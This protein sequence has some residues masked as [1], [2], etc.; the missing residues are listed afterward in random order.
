[1]SLNRW[2][3]F[4][5]LEQDFVRTLEFVEFDKNNEKAFSNEYAKVLLLAGSE[6][7]VV[8]K[9]VCGKYAPKQKA[10]NIEDYRKAIVST[11]KDIHTISIDISR[12]NLSLT[13]WTNWN[14]SIAKSP[15]WWQ[16]YNSVKHDREK[17]FPEANL[18]NTINSLCGLFA[19]LLYIFKDEKHPHP[20]PEFLDYGFP[21]YIVTAG[22]RKL[23]GT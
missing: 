21:E 5:N 7:D 4:L 20:Y 13:P 9:L 23:P 22:G 15:D 6:V 8:A 10:D 1:M 18:A 11:F 19:L 3:Y 17:C 2:H 12:H 14:P 16:A